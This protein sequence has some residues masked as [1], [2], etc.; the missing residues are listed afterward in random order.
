MRR[1][2]FTLFF[3]AAASTI[4]WSEERAKFNIQ[5]A[6]EPPQEVLVDAYLK[7]LK[8]YDRD[9]YYKVLDILPFFAGKKL[10][11]EEEMALRRELGE[12]LLRSCHS[13]FSDSRA[14]SKEYFRYNLADKPDAR[15]TL[16]QGIFDYDR[17]TRISAIMSIRANRVL[18]ALPALFGLLRKDLSTQD[19]EEM[20]LFAS[21]T[22]IDFGDDYAP[23]S[24]PTIVGFLGV[25]KW[26]AKACEILI[27]HRKLLGPYRDTIKA[28]YELASPTLRG[29]LEK[30]LK[31]LTEASGAA[32]P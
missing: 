2:F 3:L 29:G 13:P 16:V 5:R 17:R 18:Q 19:D 21:A 30:L 25:E 7:A 26:S 28:E 8:P 11:T 14:M 10:A 27:K 22:I 31:E 32:G 4:T 20:R 1:L 24:I 9:F 6:G 12:K 23:L 15:P